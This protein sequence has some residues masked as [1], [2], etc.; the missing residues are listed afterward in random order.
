MA[1]P[2][3]SAHGRPRNP[4][5]MSTAR[6]KWTLR[7]QNSTATGRKATSASARMTSRPASHHNAAS[8]PTV[9]SALNSSLGTTSA[10]GTIACASGGGYR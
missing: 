10:I 4:S 2:T 1:E 3:D 9:H 7:N 5:T 6:N 8:M